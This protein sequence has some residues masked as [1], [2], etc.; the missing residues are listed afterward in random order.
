MLFPIVVRKKSDNSYGVTM[1]DFPGCFTAGATFDEAI[2]RVQKAVESH[3][4]KDNKIPEPSTV[5]SL[6]NKLDYDGRLLVMVDIDVS[7]FEPR[8]KRV[9]ISIP[10][11]LLHEIDSFA[12]KQG[13]SRSGF[14][15]QAAKDSFKAAQR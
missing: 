11:N 4:A 8:A 1:P 15:A 12:K 7:A 13:L 2:S 10:E 3:L 6:A 9:N 5:E 14:L